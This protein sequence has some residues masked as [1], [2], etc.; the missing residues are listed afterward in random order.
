MRV[1]LCSYNGFSLAVPARSVMSIFIFREIT[2]EKKTAYQTKDSVT[3]ISLPLLFNA[4]FLKTHHGIIIKNDDNLSQSDILLSTEIE[5][6]DD[7]PLDKF[8][9]VPKTLGVFGFSLFF[10]GIH[11]NE[12]IRNE[13]VLL[14]DPQKLII[15]IKK[16]LAS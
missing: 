14:L 11:F 6:E 9:P 16:E 1:F 5:S 2:D 15:K 4:P 3:Y 13:P 8:Y 12:K 7:I 10:S